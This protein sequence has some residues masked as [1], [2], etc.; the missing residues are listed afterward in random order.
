[1]IRKPDDDEVQDYPEE[2]V[3]HTDVTQGKDKGCKDKTKVDVS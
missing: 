2:E 3:S 1:M